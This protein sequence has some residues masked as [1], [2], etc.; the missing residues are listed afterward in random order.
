M[1]V[2]A[3]CSAISTASLTRAM[4]QRCR[5]RYSQT[6]H[7]VQRQTAGSQQTY[8][9]AGEPHAAYKR[10]S[11]SMVM[12]SASFFFDASEGALAAFHFALLSLP[13]LQ[14]AGPTPC[15]VAM[16]GSPENHRDGV[17]TCDDGEAI[18]IHI[19]SE[20]SN[21]AQVENPGHTEARE[22]RF[23]FDTQGASTSGFAWRLHAVIVSVTY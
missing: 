8:H 17:S 11:G 20:Q 5:K 14:S 4:L 21:L 18:S 12:V 13:I 10:L 6:Q 22:L 3:T 1:L 19:V 9:N 7:K 16:F 23:P 15:G 2:K